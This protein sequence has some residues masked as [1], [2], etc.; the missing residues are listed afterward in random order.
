MIVLRNREIMRAAD[1]LGR[2]SCHITSEGVSYVAYSDDKTIVAFYLDAIGI[3]CH[4]DAIG[5][6]RRRDGATADAIARHNNPDADRAG[7]N[8]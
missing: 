4:L 5:I 3:I 6:I 2:R 7:R 1:P 8:A